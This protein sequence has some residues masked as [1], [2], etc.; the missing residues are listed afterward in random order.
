[1]A[2]CGIITQENLPIFK[3]YDRIIWHNFEKGIIDWSKNT[4]PFRYF[5]IP[6]SY[7]KYTRRC[8]TSIDPGVLINYDAWS[9][10]LHRKIEIEI[11]SIKKGKRLKIDDYESCVAAGYYVDVPDLVCLERSGLL[12]SKE[13][14]DK[15]L[16][17][18]DKIFGVRPPYTCAKYNPK[19]PI[20]NCAE[21]HV[22]NSLMSSLDRP[23]PLK[24]STAVR[25]RTMTYKN[26]CENC[27]VIMANV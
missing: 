8:I 12:T 15:F 23:A 10:A 11:H 22:V 3:H 19:N 21:Q 5:I 7:V 24:V 26:N 16:L 25:P 1:M 27:K 13:C 2:I 14:C 18:C 4:R 6:F 20:G 9:Y 17:L